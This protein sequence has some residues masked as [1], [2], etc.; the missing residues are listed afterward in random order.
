KQGLI[1]KSCVN[2][3]FLRG[4]S[5]ASF[6]KVR[7]RELSVRMTSSANKARIKPGTCANKV[8]LV[9]LALMLFAMTAAAQDTVTGAFEGIVSD[10]QTGAPLKGAAVQIINEQT[11]VTANL[12]TDYRGR[13]YQGLLLPGTYRVR[14]AMPGYQTRE[15]LQRLKITY[16]GEVVPVPVA[17]DPAPAAVTPGATPT[18]A[19][20]LSVED[21]DIRSSLIRTDGRRAGSFSEDEVL[22]L[23]IG[24]ATLTRSFDELA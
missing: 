20:S 19:P 12:L 17:L 18:P 14:V 21:T 16:T 15:V 4:S 13:F 10:S 11:G 6:D 8:V 9:S 1:L 22:A 23:P 7:T 5:R 3:P 2:H 24:G